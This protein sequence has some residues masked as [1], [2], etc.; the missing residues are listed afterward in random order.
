MSFFTAVGGL[1]VTS[2]RMV[3]GAAIDFPLL[4]R[5][6][7]ATDNPLLPASPSFFVLSAPETM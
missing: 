2:P 7:S 4:K 1:G 3:S 6:F 5:S